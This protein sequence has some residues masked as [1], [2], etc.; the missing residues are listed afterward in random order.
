MAQEVKLQLRLPAD[1]H[2]WVTEL[3]KSN[4]R[5]LNGQLVYLIRE[6]KLRGKNAKELSA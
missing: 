2:K 6:D 3:A 4:E 5:S 1:I